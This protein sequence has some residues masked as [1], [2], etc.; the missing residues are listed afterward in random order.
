MR[1]VALLFI[2]LLVLSPVALAS[3]SFTDPSGD[4][5]GDPDITSVTLSHTDTTVTIAVE[6]DS[7]PPL[8]FS[9][10]DGYTDMLLVGIHTDE[11]LSRRDVE[12]WTGVHAVDVTSAMVVRG[13]PERGVVGT[14]DVSVSGSTVALD[15]ERDL[16]GDPDEIGIQ[17][18]A[19]RESVSESAAVGRG[20]EAPDSGPHAYMLG[21][22]G[23]SFWIWPVAGVAAATLVVLALVVALRSG[24]LHR[25]RVLR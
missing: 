13:G 1:I 8:G 2:A 24:R 19:G 5:S 17:V 15:V 9:E 12:F 3:D 21:D 16:L 7:V 10:S 18:A 6:F 25:H 20:D 23:G 22:G 11:D 4:S 14:A